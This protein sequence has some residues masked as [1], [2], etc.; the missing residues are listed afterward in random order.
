MLRAS[1]ARVDRLPPIGMLGEQV[2]S[3]G[4][5]AT[6]DDSGEYVFGLHYAFDAIR[7]ER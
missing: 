2:Y 6:W 7:R 1:L 3:L 5:G 4:G